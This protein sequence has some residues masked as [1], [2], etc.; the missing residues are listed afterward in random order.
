MKTNWQHI[1]NSGACPTHQKLAMYHF[2]QLSGEERFEIENHLADCEMCSDYIEGLSLLQS[3]EKL[4]ETEA[5]LKNRIHDLIYKKEK[6]FIISPLFKRLAIAASLLL[7]VSLSFYLIQQFS[8]PKQQLAEKTA[9]SKT[10]LEE[11]ETEKAP[12]IENKKTPSQIAQQVE[13]KPIEYKDANKAEEE[14]L[15]EIS[16]NDLSNKSDEILTEPVST[17][18]SSGAGIPVVEKSITTNHLMSAQDKSINE[19]RTIKGSVL[20]E[21]GKPLSGVVINVKGKNQGALT[22]S[23]GQFSMAVNKDD[24][25]LNIESVGY[26]SETPSIK[27]QNEVNLKLK[28]N[29]MSLEEVVVESKNNETSL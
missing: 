25:V 6:K 8:T 10:L 5:E 2:D 27:N 7:I 22:D 24:S 18:N 21:M 3:N 1:I 17:E 28:P 15:L 29:L 4:N 26:L 20:D 19:T 12:I 16:S 13:K 14:P 11:K 23:N 9:P